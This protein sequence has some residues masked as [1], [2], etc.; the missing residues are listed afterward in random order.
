MTSLFLQARLDSKRLPNKAL[1]DI[2]GE[3][4]ISV[5]MKNLKNIDA[6]NYILLTCSE[7]EDIFKPICDSCGF[8]IFIGP[9]DD[10]LKTVNFKKKVVRD[11][12]DIYNIVR[13]GIYRINSPQI[14]QYLLKQLDS[15]SMYLKHSAIKAI[16]SIGDIESIFMAL[17][18][19]SL[20]ESTFHRQLFLDVMNDFKGD[21]DVLD[22]ELL[23]RISEFDN[24]IKCMIIDYY[25]IE[26]FIDAK[27]E[28]YNLFLH[29]DS[30]LD[31]KIVIIRYF[32][33]I[34]YDKFFDCIVD[35]LKNDQ[36]EIRA[37]CAKSLRE[38]KSDASVKALSESI[39]DPNWHVRFNSATTLVKYN[40]DED[41]IQNIINSG[42]T[43]A[44]E[45][46]LYAISTK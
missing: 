14:N 1:L 19:K 4:L 36:W 25:R 16:F 28:L 9:K 5:V 30:D 22:N 40:V 39:K 29:K 2:N 33:S 13:L 11:Y 6:D 18:N 34:K 21:K 24:R 32:G 42:D 3:T 12:K 35:N 46:L 7:C 41:I 37:T 43:F 8:D 10:V 23:H 27:E 31:T 45:I 38:Y 15:D 20:N 17:K 26:K 44:K